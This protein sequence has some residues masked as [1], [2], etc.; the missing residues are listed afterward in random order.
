LCRKGN[1]F[2]VRQVSIFWWY[3]SLWMITTVFPLSVYVTNYVFVVCCGIILLHKFVSY[4]KSNYASYNV[5]VVWFSSMSDVEKY[6]ACWSRDSW[7]QFPYGWQCPI[8]VIVLI[9]RS[10]AG[11]RVPNSSIPVS[12]YKRWISVKFLNFRVKLKLWWLFFIPIVS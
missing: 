4:L 9:F 1:M 7:R 2:C 8:D 10:C 11:I 12:S 6:P 3:V 5:T